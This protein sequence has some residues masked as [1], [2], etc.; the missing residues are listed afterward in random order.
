MSRPFLY[1]LAGVN[2]AG[3]S[4]VGGHVLREAGL[5]WFNPDTFARGLRELSGLSQA[6]ANAQA[7]QE[8][9]NRIRDALDQGRNHAFET[10]LGGNSIAALL[11]EASHSHDVLMWFC[12]LSSPEQHIA[13]VQARVRSGGHPINEADIRRRWPLAQQNLVRLMPVL[14]Q[15]QVYDNSAD[16]APGEAVSDPQLLLQM[17]DG[18][19][20]YPE[21]DDLAQLAATPAWATP[22]LE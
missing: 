8:G 21:P 10:T 4:S 12:G 16:A 14:A 11:H 13:R 17:E 15:L 2:G 7:W 18:Q 6:E 20:L 22:L 1:V 9:V 5:D 19:L 3:K